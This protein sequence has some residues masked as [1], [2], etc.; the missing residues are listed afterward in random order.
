MPEQDPANLPPP[1]QL[2]FRR[3][4]HAVD[5]AI[6]TCI[7]CKRPID[8]AYFQANGNTLCPQC[9]ERLK[10]GQQ[11]SHSSSLFRAVLYGAGAAIAGAAIYASVAIFL[12]LEIGIVAILIGY[13]VGKAVRHATNGKGG[14]PQQILAVALTYFSITTSYIPVFIYQAS[15]AK[16]AAENPQSTQ[17]AA[18]QD[19]QPQRST[20][21]QMPSGRVLV[22]VFAL[23]AAAPFLALFEGGNPIS[24]LISLF[25][26]FIGLRQAWVLTRGSAIIITGP[27]PLG[28]SLTIP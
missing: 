24:A 8:S 15:K 28:Q 20:G 27:H 19:Q 25:I 23:A 21:I 11:A 16:I 1:E 17:G 3:A 4:Q 22:T 14:R 18:R 6:K 9:A 7:V 2:Q 12:H 5:P 13:M 10:T 26:I